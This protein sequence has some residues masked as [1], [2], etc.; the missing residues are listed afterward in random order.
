MNTKKIICIMLSALALLLFISL[1][2]A[3]NKIIDFPYVAATIIGQSPDPAEPGDLVELRFNI[4][5]NGSGILEDATFELIPEWPL[6]LAPAQDA[7]IS[8]G[9]LK[10]KDRY[11]DKTADTVV[12]LFYRLKVDPKA[13]SGNYQVKLEYTS[14]N[15]YT[16]VQKLPVYEVRVES[17]TTL[18]DIDSF[19]TIPEKIKLGKA[20][21][22]LIKL[23][24]KGGVDL[25][26][27]KVKLDLD[28]VDI[29]PVDSTNEKLINSLQKDYSTM[30]EYNLLASG[31][32]KA[33]EYTIPMNIEF[34]DDNNNKYTKNNT[35]T[36][37]MDSTPNYIMNLEQSEL[38]HPSS[39]GKIVISL[40][41][42]GQSDLKFVNLE[43]IDTQDYEVLGKRSE[44]LGNLESDDYETAD[45]EI[46]VNGINFADNAEKR[47][48]PLQL[49]ISYKDSYNTDYSDEKE[50]ILPVYTKAAAKKYGLIEGS[51]LFKIF[52][53]ILILVAVIGYIIYRKRKKKN[54]G[55]K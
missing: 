1:A 20:G 11:S 5:N 32:L 48:L 7:K 17:S 39:K 22:L 6:T 49:K 36:L 18:L 24:N 29:S 30:V 13:P 33:K 25:K 37:L 47:N 26:D 23:S 53:F 16:G 15:K 40:S 42:T 2:S 8:V 4:W 44:Y 45:F 46:Y 10:T 41:N 50:V 35:V 12:L 34:R 27:I 3:S 21:K 14:K 52:L 38:Y 55:S 54:N 28:N 31:E 19:Q 9:D 43:L 51:S